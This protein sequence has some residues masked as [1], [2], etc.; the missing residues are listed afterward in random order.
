M[1]LKRVLELEN[2]IELPLTGMVE[3]ALKSREKWSALSSFARTVLLRK[4]KAERVRGRVA[5]Q[6]RR[7]SNHRELCDGSL[8]RARVIVT[9]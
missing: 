2:S 5:I 1:E 8:V 7:C 3:Q 4:E 6:R 9:L